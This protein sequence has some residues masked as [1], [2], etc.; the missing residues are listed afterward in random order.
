MTEGGGAGGLDMS[1]DGGRR[2]EG[3]EG[4]EGEEDEGGCGDQGMVDTSQWIIENLEP[5]ESCWTKFR[6]E[7]HQI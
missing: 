7:H 6:Y 3:A 2:G 4:G 5:D 1:R